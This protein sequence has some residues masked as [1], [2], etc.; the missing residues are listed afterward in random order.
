MGAEHEALWHIESHFAL[1]PSLTQIAQAIELSPFNLS[2]QFQLTMARYLRVRRLTEAAQ[3]LPADSEPILDA[4]LAV[5]CVSHAAFMPSPNGS[6]CLR[7][8]FVVRPRAVRGHQAPCRVPALRRTTPWGQERTLA[9][10]QSGLTTKRLGLG[11]CIEP[12]LT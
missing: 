3:I 8:R 1:N 11:R 12:A 7:N 6:S 4:A 10:P 2:R 5:G 9:V